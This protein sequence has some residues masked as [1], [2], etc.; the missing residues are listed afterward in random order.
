VTVGVDNRTYLLWTHTSG[1][2]SLWRVSATGTFELAT[3]Y[4]PY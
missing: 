4:G 2:I 1:Q 3:S